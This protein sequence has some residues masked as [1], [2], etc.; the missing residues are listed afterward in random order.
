MTAICDIEV[1]ESQICDTVVSVMEKNAK[2]IRVKVWIEDDDGGTF[3]GAGQLKI[4]EVIDEKGSIS[5]AAKEMKM[6]YRSMWGKLKKIEERFGRPVL[7]RQ[8]GGS[9]GGSSVL[10]PEARE[11]IDKFRQLKQRINTEAQTAL[12]KIF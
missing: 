3:F 6:G 1:T 4:L 8:K 2:N 12:S 7:I 5:A 9:S 10:T 11:L